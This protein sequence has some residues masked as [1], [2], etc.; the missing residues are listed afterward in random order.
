MNIFFFSTR[1]KTQRQRK[2]TK[3]FFFLFIFLLLLQSPLFSSFIFFFFF[4]NS[5]L[6]NLNY[7]DSEITKLQEF[8]QVQAFPV[9]WHT[10][11]L[12][13]IPRLL[14][15]SPSTHCSTGI[16]QKLFFSGLFFFV[17]FKNLFLPVRSKRESWRQGEFTTLRCSE[18][19]LLSGWAV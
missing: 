11:F 12:H 3:V 7:V 1:H 16:S 6:F 9:P 4:F 17:C 2:S 10:Q 5:L 15:P 19:P 14:P 8:G 18:H 13:L